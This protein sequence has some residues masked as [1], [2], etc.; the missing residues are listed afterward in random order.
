MALWYVVVHICA[1]FL[2]KYG[3][4]WA[5]L[6]LWN[7]TWFNQKYENPCKMGT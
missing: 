6:T 2:G 7:P 4:A 5:I 3:L 1:Q